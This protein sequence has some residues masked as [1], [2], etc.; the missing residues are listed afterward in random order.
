[1]SKNKIRNTRADTIFHLM[2]NT[3][4]LIFFLLVIIPLISVVSHSISD[5]MTVY[6]GKVF[7][8]P[9]NLSLI[10]YQTLLNDPR[11]GQGYLNTIFYT[12]VGTMI[13]LVMTVMAAFPLSRKYFY[14]RKFFN[15][16][17]TFTML[18]SGGLIPRYFLVRDLG[19]L[20]TVWAMMIPGA[21]SVWNVMICRTAFSTT[22]SDDLQEAAALDGCGDI[23]FIIRI[24]IPLS[25]SILAV[26][27]LLYA[28]GHW[29]AYFDAMIF[30]DSERLYP[31]QL[32]LRSIFA[33]SQ[34][35]DLTGDFKEQA[36]RTA[37][38][39]TMKYSLIVVASL[40]L[41]IAYPFVQKFFVK[42][43]MIGSL[44]G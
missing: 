41:M 8:L 26:M 38:V 6:S 20:D 10:S 43:V 18:F 4:L 9:K 44:K 11:I 3:L 32:I 42:G 37:L 28:V 17:F 15:L 5:P 40:P 1:M 22:I 14:G 36:M 34:M 25:G 23:Y 24:V 33:S 12:V 35:N 31:L 16:M 2:N 19:L 30:L 39:E 29:N 27:A 7:L 21:M 13:N